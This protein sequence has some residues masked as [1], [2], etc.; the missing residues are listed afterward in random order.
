MKNSFIH[1]FIHLFLIIG[2]VLVY[3]SCEKD[4]ITETPTDD[5]EVSFKKLGHEDIDVG[6]VY[7]LSSISDE[8]L[9]ELLIDPNSHS[10]T[11]QWHRVRWESDFPGDCN[12]PHITSPW[13]TQTSL[14]GVYVWAAGPSF[15]G[16]WQLDWVDDTGSCSMSIVDRA[17]V[18]VYEVDHS[19]FTPL[20]DDYFPNSGGL[21][22]GFCGLVTTTDGGITWSAMGSCP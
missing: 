18:Q 4:N 13:S 22:V 7:P 19:I 16:T 3:S 14:E 9:A 5:Y 21:S 11:H 6:V 10:R 15:D 1:S 2:F 20:S 17:R 12:I 8:V